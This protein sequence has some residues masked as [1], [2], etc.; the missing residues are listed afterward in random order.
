LLPRQHG[1]ICR[2]S[3]SSGSALCGKVSVPPAS[4]VSGPGVSS[5][6][7]EQP[8]GI[9]PFPQRPRAGGNRVWELRSDRPPQPFLFP[10]AVC[11]GEE[12]GEGWRGARVVVKPLNHRHKA[13]SLRNGGLGNRARC[14]WLICSQENC[15]VARGKK[16]TGGGWWQSAAMPQHHRL[17]GIA[18]LCH[19]PP[20]FDHSSTLQF[21][22][23]STKVLCCCCGRVVCY[24][25]DICA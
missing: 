11:G 24:R 18:A 4:C 17:W 9:R 19:Q 7:Q 21:P 13:V 16:Q 6:N 14:P 2:M 10:A 25:Q 20:I 22:C 23:N 5:R 1:H 15:K 8:P 12:E 3:V